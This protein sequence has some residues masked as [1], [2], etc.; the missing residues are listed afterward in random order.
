MATSWVAKT[1][2]AF[3]PP[4]D[5][6]YWAF[7]ATLFDGFGPYFLAIGWWRVYT[8]LVLN[9]LPRTNDPLKD[10]PSSKQRRLCKAILWMSV[11]LHYYG[12]TRM[13]M[14]R[15]GQPIDTLRANYI[16]Q[17]APWLFLGTIIFAL[18]KVIRF[19]YLTTFHPA[20]RF[21]SHE[22]NA[23]IYLWLA[24]VAYVSLFLQT[25]Y[26]AVMWSPTLYTSLRTWLR[27]HELMQGCWWLQWLFEVLPTV[28]LLAPFVFGDLLPTLATS[29]GNGE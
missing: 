9:K 15:N 1:V 24:C 3:R 23:R 12:V 13:Y 21:N 18:T 8:T 2:G 19:T 11:L 14:Y 22:L 20:R 6:L 27:V 10:L 5:K 4:K 29:R 16:R 26:R 28:V 17:H 7:A 25:V